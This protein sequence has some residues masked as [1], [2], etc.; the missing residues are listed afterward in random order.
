M[1]YYIKCAHW[2]LVLSLVV[3]QLF[4]YMYKKLSHYNDD[5]IDRKYSDI[6]LFFSV[7]NTRVEF[8]W[9]R[10]ESVQ[11]DRPLFGIRLQI[12]PCQTADRQRIDSG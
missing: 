9:V 11:T 1:Y 7:Q 5:C 8:D 3:L 10:R 6:I 12:I 4:V 2:P